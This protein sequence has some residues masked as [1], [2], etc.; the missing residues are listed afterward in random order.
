MITYKLRFPAKSIPTESLTSLQAPDH[1]CYGH[2]AFSGVE[3]IEFIVLPSVR[4]N[5]AY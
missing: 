4:Y 5:F 1:A 3:E 2:G